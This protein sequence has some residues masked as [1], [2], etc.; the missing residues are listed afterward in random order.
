ME[1]ETLC[2]SLMGAY[3]GEKNHWIM[4]N[5]M[6]SH[7][8]RCWIV[9]LEQSNNGRYWCKWGEERLESSPGDGSCRSLPAEILYIKYNFG[10]GF[11]L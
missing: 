1:V 8:S 10:L 9:Y 5:G 6:K 3:R 2:V 7:Q 4:I 11:N